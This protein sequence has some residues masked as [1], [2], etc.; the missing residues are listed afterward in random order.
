[1]GTVLGSA[2]VVAFL[3][4]MGLDFKLRWDSRSR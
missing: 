4:V 1:M 2:A 3:A